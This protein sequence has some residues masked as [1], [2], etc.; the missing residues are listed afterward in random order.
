MEA[1]TQKAVPE[2]RVSCITPYKEWNPEE[3]QG[4]EAIL[5]DSIMAGPHHYIFVKTHSVY[6]ECR[7]PR[8]NTK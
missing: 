1:K 5:F 3:F 2:F 8:V 6:L 4:S 7:T